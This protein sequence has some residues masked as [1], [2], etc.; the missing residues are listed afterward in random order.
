MTFSRRYLLEMLD[1][2]GISPSDGDFRA[3]V[4]QYILFHFDLLAEE[5]VDKKGFRAICSLIAS[6]VSKWYTEEADYHLDRLF[7]NHKVTKDK[8]TLHRV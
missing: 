8:H 7:D 1:K 5:V 6:K 4:E 3:R 2:N